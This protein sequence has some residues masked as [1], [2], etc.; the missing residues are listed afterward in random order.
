[1]FVPAPRSSRSSPRRAA[2]KPPNARANARA[3]A[4]L[5][6]AN[7]ALMAQKRAAAGFPGIMRSTGGNWTGSL[8]LQQQ[9][10]DCGRGLASML[11]GKIAAEQRAASWELKY[12]NLMA[13][14]LALKG[15]AN[16]YAELSHVRPS[17]SNRVA[18]F[19]KRR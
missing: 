18:A 15:K 16:R 9:L 5:G 13:R 12:R 3:Y 17:V 19:E 11:Q 2:P 6:N 4:P 1:M 8:G 14:Y 7:R 10:D